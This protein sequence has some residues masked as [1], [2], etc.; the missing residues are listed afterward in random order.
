MAYVKVVFNQQLKLRAKALAVIITIALFS[1]I[2]PSTTITI[3][4]Q[5]KYYNSFPTYTY[6]CKA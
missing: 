1:Q 4:P 3:P 2:T 6:N 5:R